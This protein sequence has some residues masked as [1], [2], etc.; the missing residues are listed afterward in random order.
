VIS[1]LGRL[2]LCRCGTTG[3]N[4]STKCSSSGCCASGF[5]M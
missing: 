5:F 2:L 1:E 4:E 3:R